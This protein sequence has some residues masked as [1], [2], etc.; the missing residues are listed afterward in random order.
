LNTVNDFLDAQIKGVKL[1]LHDAGIDGF[2]PA[3]FD[4]F[5]VPKYFPIDFQTQLPATLHHVPACD[6][7][8]L[9]YPRRMGMMGRDHPSIFIGPQNSESKTHVDA[10]RTRFWMAMI[11]GTKHWHMF[12]PQDTEHLYATDEGYPGG[13]IE[14]HYPGVFDVDT[15]RPDLDLWP[16]LRKATV[17]NATITK[18]DVLFIPEDWPH[19][20]YNPGASVALAYNYVDRHNYGKWK[21]HEEH[22]MKTTR[23]EMAKRSS[24]NTWL[25]RHN[26]T[27][28]DFN[29]MKQGEK[30]ALPG[31]VGEDIDGDVDSEDYTSQGHWM[32]EILVE[33][34]MRDP[35]WPHHIGVGKDHKEEHFRDWFRRQGWRMPPYSHSAMARNMRGLAADAGQPSNFV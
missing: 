31:G 16:N 21:R 20:V 1:Y 27:E 8:Q 24:R 35:T 7:S 30:D 13:D 33:K 25:K 32:D 29:E 26:K 28:H 6:P 4:Y 5:K 18:G 14:G 15:F 9:E 3:L 17:W 34:V 10:R 12:H 22:N 19:Q 2:C 23:L 11:N